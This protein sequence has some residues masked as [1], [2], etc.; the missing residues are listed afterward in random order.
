[1]TKEIND[2]LISFVESSLY[3]CNEACNEIW[4]TSQTPHTEAEYDIVSGRPF[5]FYGITLQYC[6]VMEYNK[7]LEKKL[8]IDSSNIASL[9][10]LNNS[11]YKFLGPEFHSKYSENRRLLK[12]L[13]NSDFYKVI[14]ELR[15]KKFGHADNNPINDPLK[16]KG[17]SGQQIDE[18]MR[19]MKVLL[20][21]ANNCFNTFEKRQFIVHNDD[22]TA[23]F[24]KYHAQYKSYYYKNY[25]KAHNEGYG[26]N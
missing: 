8:N 7:L 22:R 26:L 12:D 21:I 24:I 11:T 3:L 15:N 1:M 6:F 18:M 17:F 13:C 25:L 2:K 4:H 10:R 19:Q 23:N 16:I 5:S 20:I 14:H 9:Y